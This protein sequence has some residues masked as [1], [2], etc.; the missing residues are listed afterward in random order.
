MKK[1]FFKILCIIICIILLT[2]CNGN[3]N[4]IPI[5]T[6]SQNKNSISS[7]D[8]NNN[9]NK[10]FMNNSDRTN[11]AKI[12]SEAGSMH[13]YDMNDDIIFDLFDFDIDSNQR[14]FIADKERIFIRYE[15]EN[16]SNQKKVTEFDSSLKFCR[17]IAIDND[18]L[19]A[20]DDKTNTIKAFGLDG[21]IIEEYD[22]DNGIYISM[23][24]KNKK[25][26]VLLEDI[27]DTAKRYII[28]YDLENKKK[29]QLKSNKVM[30]FSLYKDNTILI[31][32]LSDHINPTFFVYDYERGEIINEYPALVNNNIF[33][34]NPNDNMLYY[35]FEGNI[36]RCSLE[37]NM[38]HTVYSDVEAIFHKLL[39]NNN[40]CY[41]LDV[42]SNKI[43]KF[44]VDTI[45][46]NTSKNIN[47]ICGRE[48]IENDQKIKMAIKLFQKSHP[49]INIQFTYINDFEYDSVMNTKF[50]ARE[51]DFD[52]YFLYSDFM[53]PYVRN[54]TY[55]DLNQY[56]SINESFNHTLKGIKGLCSYKEKIIGVPY[57]ISSN[58]WEVNDDLLEQ[59]GLPC[60]EGR[61]TW[62][63]F[64]DYAKQAR[65]DLNNDGTLNT[66][67]KEV[68]MPYSIPLWLEEYE[69]KY[70]NILEKKA[71]YV[72]EI[73]INLL[74]MWKNVLDEGLIKEATGKT[75]IM[76]DN[77]LFHD[78]SM[79]LAK[80]S[81]NIIPPPSI[82]K[83]SKFPAT[84]HMM[85]VNLWSKNKEIAIDFLC[86][87]MSVDVQKINA[88]RPI[89][90]DLSLY[91]EIQ[92]PNNVRLSNGKNYSL[93]KNM[94]ENSIRRSDSSNIDFRIYRIS[95]IRE[96]L[97]G[98]LSA[99]KAAELIDKKADMVLN[100]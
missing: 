66:Y 17:H 57:N 36:K 77:I 8:I 78:E 20:L 76:K 42:E 26:F 15:D 80:G 71:D 25:A 74:N 51:V 14:I 21:T 93:C 43:I 13:S 22:I 65:K 82:E 39:F 53:E 4:N 85:C 98:K 83:E 91:D 97:S 49:D 48:N 6:D 58:A 69:S 2:S 59:I 30:Y 34:Y 32:D 55:E 96:F 52:I 64:Y 50:M 60:P 12:C 18:I 89:I 75:F 62:E 41:A 40:L 47:I 16:S 67:I 73:F 27:H 11:E 72:N 90:N 44:N 84:I 7:G 86:K 38:T 88:N 29:E 61:W 5:S 56:P 23:K 45:S 37:S 100:E 94:F 10:E 79:T 70:L 81:K 95:T 87:Y 19:Y 3:K 54:S 63:Q 28:I 24:C 92:G 1:I 31:L 35:I 99:E 33:F 68:R 9:V 46:T